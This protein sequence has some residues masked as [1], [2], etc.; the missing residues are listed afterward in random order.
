MTQ[1]ADDFGLILSH[2]RVV[3][4]AIYIHIWSTHLQRFPAPAGEFSG[5]GLYRPS[6]SP[7]RC[8]SHRRRTCTIT[9]TDNSHFVGI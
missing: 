5:F 4:N 1:Y 9:V 2:F 6:L 8:I 3:F 7:L